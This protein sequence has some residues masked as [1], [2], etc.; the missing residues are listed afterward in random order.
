MAGLACAKTETV[1]G[2]SDTGNARKI[3]LHKHFLPNLQSKCVPILM[4]KRRLMTS[5]GIHQSFKKMLVPCR[6]AFS[7]SKLAATFHTETFFVSS[8]KARERLQWPQ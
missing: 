8:L 7:L 5:N 1:A 6:A 3:S 4:K 2:N